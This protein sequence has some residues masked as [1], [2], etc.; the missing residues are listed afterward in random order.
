M[1]RR[2]QQAA[3]SGYRALD[4]S[5]GHIGTT[6]VSNEALSAF[7]KYLNEVE[8]HGMQARVCWVLTEMLE[9]EKAESP[10]WGET[11]EEIQIFNTSKKWNEFHLDPR[12]EKIA[13]EKYRKEMDIQKRKFAI[14]AEL[15]Q[16]R[17]LPYLWPGANRKWVVRWQIQ[18]AKPRVKRPDVTIMDDSNALQLILDF[19]RAGQL[20]RLR[21]CNC[22]QRWL[23]AKFKHQNFCSTKC[24][25]KH[26][27][28]SPEWKEKR[29][30]YMRSY[31]EQTMG[32]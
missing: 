13:P 29:R 3:P 23:F 7:I 30:D 6:M 14:I 22:C 19:A 21:R 15:S 8:P 25:Q 28:Q 9:L 17:F 4:L 1:R 16:H 11:K 5:L 20:N 12:L 10:L 27:S 18:N 31:R 32:K 26:Y 24:Q 2:H